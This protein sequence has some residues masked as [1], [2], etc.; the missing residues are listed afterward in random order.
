MVG[1]TNSRPGKAGL[2]PAPLQ[3]DNN[4]FL[5]GDGSWVDINIPTFD[6]NAF[7]TTNNIVSLQG[8]NLASVGSV[9]IKTDS[10]IQW[11]TM[12]PGRINKQITTLAKLQAQ[13]SGEDLDP[14]DLDAIYLVA[15]E[16]PDSSSNYDEY[17]IVNGALERLGSFG[18]VDLTNYVQIPTFNTAIGQIHEELY[19]STDPR[20]G[21][22]IPGLISRVT[23]IEATYVTQSQIGNLQTL[24]LS[25]GNTTLVEEVNTINR[26]LSDVKDRLKWDNLQD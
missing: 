13:L 9:P 4:R 2:V 23:N 22:T 6:S 14:L 5:A 8:Y 15:S 10:G 26:S 11:S 20:N 17:M 21:S 18:Q 24:L 19:D 25:P 7:A 3:G 1:A 12:S 16:D